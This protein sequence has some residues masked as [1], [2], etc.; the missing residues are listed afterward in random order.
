MR[1]SFSVIVNDDKS[2]THSSSRRS[3]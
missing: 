1:S 3:W 2:V